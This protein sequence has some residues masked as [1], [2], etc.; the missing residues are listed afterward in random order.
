MRFATLTFRTSQ[1]GLAISIALCW[2][3]LAQAQTTCFGIPATDTANVCSG[4]GTCVAPDTCVCVVGYT[5]V[6]CQL[7]LVCNGISSTDPS[8]CSG[9][10]TC[11]APD[12]CECVVGYTGQFCQLPTCNGISS[13]D[14]SVCSGHGVC[15]NPD[16]CVCD[17]GYSSVDCSTLTVTLNADPLL[18]GAGEP[19]QLTWSSPAAATCAATGAWAGSMP[20]SGST[21]VLVTTTSFFQLDCVDA[22]ASPGADSV[23]VTVSGVVNDAC[24]AA[25]EIP[26]AG[27]FPFDDAVDTL[28]ATAHA[29]DPTPVCGSGPDGST[30]WYRYTAPISGTFDISTA[31]SDYDTVVSA[32][33]GCGSLVTSVACNDDG[34]TPPQSDLVFSVDAGSTYLFQVGDRGGGAGGQLSVSAIPE[35]SREWLI[36]AA[37]ATLLLLRRFE[38][39]QRVGERMAA[40]ER[41]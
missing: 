19:T 39:G 34:A 18:L 24:L 16:L 27:P 26:A 23:T 40:P 17:V 28:G 8:V 33:D 13:T 35:P 6:F 9:H 37:L 29:S 20:V 21:G 32:W 1:L 31:G 11:T 5:G 2:C 3:G 14:A 7:L 25:G 15:V 10:G 41:S 22:L 36:L 4:R 38:P 30:V 12:N